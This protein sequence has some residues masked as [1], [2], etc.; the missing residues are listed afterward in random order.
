MSENPRLSGFVPLPPRSGG[1]SDPRMPAGRALAL[2]RELR[3]EKK[4]SS[5]DL[6][7]LLAVLNPVAFAEAADGQS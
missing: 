4:I 2:V 3:Q 7:V 5:A 1:T 6:D